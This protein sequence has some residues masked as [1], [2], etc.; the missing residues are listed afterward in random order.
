MATDSMEKL[1]VEGLQEM[2]YTEQ[3]L[4]DALETLSQQTSNDAASQAFSDHREETQGHVD[5]LEQV[6]EAMGEEPQTRE[7]RVVD[8]L[9]QEHEEFASENDG[10]ILDRYNAAVGQKTEHYEIAAY[11]NLTSLAG[12]L[13]YDEAA[14]LL[15]E[16]LREEENAL[17]EV[18][19][20]SEQFDEQQVA[21]D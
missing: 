14:D 4:V 2:Y 5:R 19:R 21:N 20:I 16:I 13:G 15:E 8:A 18:T 7:E 10:D 3:Q 17:E 1:L 11:G 12:K 6:F 9:I